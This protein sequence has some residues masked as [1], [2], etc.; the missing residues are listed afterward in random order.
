MKNGEKD[1]AIKKQKVDKN[2]ATTHWT[3]WEFSD[4]LIHPLKAVYPQIFQT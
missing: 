1:K 4:E 3:Q 2:T